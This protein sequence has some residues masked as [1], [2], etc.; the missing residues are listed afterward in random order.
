MEAYRN[1]EHDVNDVV[2]WTGDPMTADRCAKRKPFDF[3]QDRLAAISTD[4]E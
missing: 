3:A 4:D 2:A 1:S